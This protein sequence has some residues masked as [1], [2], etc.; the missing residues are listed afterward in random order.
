MVLATTLQQDEQFK[1][2]CAEIYESSCFADLLI[3]SGS[4][5][6]VSGLLRLE[7]E[8]AGC[9]ASAPAGSLLQASGNEPFWS[10]LITRQGLML[11]SPTQPPL[12]LPHIEEALPDGSLY[13]SSQADHQLLQIWLTPGHCIDSM[14]GAYR[15]LNARLEWQG[16]ILS[17]CA[18]YATDNPATPPVITP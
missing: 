5:T 9:A 17:G 13:Y 4:P 16:Q 11:S 2:S 6:T 18:Y 7:P 14:S 8:G 15:H 10:V 1:A 12:A 3:S